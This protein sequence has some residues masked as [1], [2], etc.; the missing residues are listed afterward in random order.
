MYAV[1]FGKESMSG[2]FLMSSMMHVED[3][4]CLGRRVGK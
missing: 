4:I 2:S 1:G 3:I